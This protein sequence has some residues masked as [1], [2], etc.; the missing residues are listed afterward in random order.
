MTR[1]MDNLQAINRPSRIYLYKWIEKHGKYGKYKSEMGGG[2]WGGVESRDKIIYLSM[3]QNKIIHSVGFYIQ[4]FV[5]K[6]SIEHR[7]KIKKF[8]SQKLFY[9]IRIF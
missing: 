1:I 4:S 9:I 2:G 6:C 7:K 3:R 5:W 8:F